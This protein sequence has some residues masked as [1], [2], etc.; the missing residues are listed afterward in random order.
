MTCPKT[1]SEKKHRHIKKS[2]NFS[3]ESASMKYNDESAKVLWL[4]GNS[5]SI[6][7]VRRSDEKFHVTERYFRDYDNILS[8]VKKYIQPIDFLI[9]YNGASKVT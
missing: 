2:L 8:E 1:N 6:D 3:L 5:D 4:T 7:I 9:M